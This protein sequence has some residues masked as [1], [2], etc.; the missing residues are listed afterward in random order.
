MRILGE[1]TYYL[2]PAKYAEIVNRC[3]DNE[4]NKRTTKKKKIDIEH[5]QVNHVD[6]LP[7]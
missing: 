5:Q 4:S 7:P 6:F 2:P 1:L 3:S